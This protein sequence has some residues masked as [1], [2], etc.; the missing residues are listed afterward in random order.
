MWYNKNV[1]SWKRQSDYIGKFSFLLRGWDDINPSQILKLVNFIWARD[2]KYTSWSQKPR[3]ER[4]CGVEPTAPTTQ[5]HTLI[6]YIII[7]ISVTIYIMVRWI[8]TDIMLI[9]CRGNTSW[10][11]GRRGFE[12]CIGHLFFLETVFILLISELM[13]RSHYPRCDSNFY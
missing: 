12:S 8:K 1:I 5:N 6:K 9:W 13:A 2:G 11:I 3:L 10:G 4:D 7:F